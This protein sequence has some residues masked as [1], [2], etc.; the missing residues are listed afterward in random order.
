MIKVGICGHYGGNKIFLDG[1]TVKTKT[2]TKELIR[3]LGE[4]QVRT[5][6]TFGGKRNIVK[7]IQGL[8]KLMRDCEHIIILPAHNSVRIFAPLMIVVNYFCH[9]KIHYIVIG[10]WLPDF[11]KRR[12]WLRK[13]L[14]GFD[15]IYVETSTMKSELEKQGLKNIE[16]LP[17]CKDIHILKPEELSYYYD[18]PYMLCTFSRVTKKKGIEDAIQAVEII[19]EKFGRIVFK[20][21]I[22]GQ[23]DDEYK[24]EFI[25]LLEKAPNY[26]QYKGTVG[27][28]ESVE[29]LKNYFALL[30][31]TYF[32]TE[33]IP[34]T[35]IDAYASGIPVIAARWKSFSDVVEENV[36]GKGYT[37]GHKEEL[38]ELLY[39]IAKQPEIIC[40][41]KE[42]CLAK[43]NEFSVEHVVL[44]WRKN[45]GLGNKEFNRSII[46][47][48]K[49]SYINDRGGG[50]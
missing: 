13:V 33:G 50:R 2:I 12:K 38:V 37:L 43:A 15:Y 29:I 26:I 14:N 36:V 47:M 17:N 18:E 19:N 31:P 32:R 45:L 48:S 3:Q 41:M 9:K 30:F 16:I 39:V 34:G 28:E 6:D 10:G 40:Q 11:I 49:K 20:L 21:D 22:Y 44:D 8:L 46:D 25:Q 23:I 24:A 27:Y 5:V 42:N 7:T 4:E 35:I 1:Q